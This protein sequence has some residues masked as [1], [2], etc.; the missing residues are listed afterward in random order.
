MSP[1]FLGP[2]KEDSATIKIKKWSTQTELDYIVVDYYPMDWEGE[3][4]HIWS[5]YKIY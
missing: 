5:F 1:S 2:T 3:T 4:N